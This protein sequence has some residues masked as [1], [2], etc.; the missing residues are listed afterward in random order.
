MIGQE[1]G[2]FLTGL[3]GFCF[4]G[5]GKM[6]KAELEACDWCMLGVLVRYFS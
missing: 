3:V 5:Y 6:A 2:V 4:L 1:V